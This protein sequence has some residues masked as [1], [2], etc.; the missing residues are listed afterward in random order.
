MMQGTVMKIT[1]HCIVVLCQDGTFR[2]LPHPPAM[3]GLGDSIVVPLSDQPK[4]RSSYKRYLKKQWIYAASLVLLLGVVFVFNYLL[5]SKQPATL[6][7]IDINPGIELIV[8]KQG[9]IDQ[10][11][12][13]ND[14]AKQLLSEEEVVNQDFYQAVQWIFTQ[15]EVQGYL[16]IE[17]E[18]KWIWLSIVDLGQGAY[19]IDPQKISAPNQGYEVEVFTANEQQLEQAKDAKLTLNKYIVLE[20]AE[21]KGI[22]LSAEQ[23]RSQ[24]ILH[25][26]QQAEVD[27][28]ELFKGSPPLGGEPL[29]N[30]ALNQVQDKSVS[31]K[32]KP[33]EEQGM[34]LDKEI[35]AKGSQGKPEGAGS[36]MNNNSSVRPSDER[37]LPAQKQT[38]ESIKAQEQSA[39]DKAEK[40]PKANSKPEIQKLKLEVK[41]AEDGEIK[42]EYKNKDGHAEAKV[43]K[44]SKQQEEKQEGQQ[45]ITFAEKVIKHLDL[46]EKSERSIV[47]SR[48]ISSLNLKQN[49]WHEIEFEVEFS[50]G[51][52]F[53]FESI[54]PLK[55]REEAKGKKKAQEQKEHEKKEK[56]AEQDR[57]NQEKADKQVK[58]IEKEK[59]KAREKAKQTE[60]EE[61]N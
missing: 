4:Q 12:L 61:K 8:N 9:M 13:L 45:A 33:N 2:N 3:P 28:E 27:P 43:E 6:V 16:D 14:E 59:E 58:E 31:E 23:L 22:H 29:T 39:A 50:D 51:S 26:L 36:I 24:S 7:A 40:T 57:K 44:K 20:L 42:L 11:N 54:N 41:L 38:D 1:E 25:S 21:E 18:K 53:E 48:V 35:P 47:V 46:Q 17:T 10:V 30:E 5:G 49:E 56:K 37:D 34:N 15:A 32:D 19:S 55:T 52:E 60:E